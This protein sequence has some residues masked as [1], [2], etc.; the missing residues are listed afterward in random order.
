MIIMY[1]WITAESNFQCRP[2]YVLSG[3]DYHVFMAYPHL[4]EEIELRIHLFSE[5]A[6]H[7]ALMKQEE[8]L[9]YID[10]QED[11]KYRVSE[12]DLFLSWITDG[13]NLS[14]KSLL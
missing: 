13:W 11:A 8:L 14:L 2:N 5:Q 10:S 1:L 3:Y 7:E 4:S 12:V 9:A 6:L